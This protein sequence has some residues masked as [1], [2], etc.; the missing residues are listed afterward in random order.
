ML[1]RRLKTMSKAAKFG[2]V[3]VLLLGVAVSLSSN[4]PPILAIG[5]DPGVGLNSRGPFGS[6]LKG[7][8]GFDTWRHP[9]GMVLKVYVMEQGSTASM[10]FEFSGDEVWPER[11]QTIKPA[12]FLD[13]SPQDSPPIPSW[14]SI[15][16]SPEKVVLQPKG[17]VNVT[18]FL[19]VGK[20]ASRGEYALIFG[21]AMVYDDVPPSKDLHVYGPLV[22]ILRVGLEK[23]SHAF[24]LIYTSSMVSGGASV[25][26]FAEG[27]NLTALLVKLGRNSSVNLNFTVISE[28]PETINARVRLANVSARM[29]NV[30]F[31]NQSKGEVEVLPNMSSRANVTIPGVS[32]TILMGGPGYVRAGDSWIYPHLNVTISI[33]LGSNG[34]V[35]EGAYPTL[36]IFET[37][38]WVLD[39]NRLDFIKHEIETVEVPIFISVGER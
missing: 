13:D 11:N 8:A 32:Q 14:L 36:F 34:E 25:T 33:M 5:G 17:R 26:Q 37:Y 15:S 19:N 2:V 35:V 7:F 12:I 10:T 31:W 39:R 24:K 21:G 6:S 29:A 23:P 28:Y 27:V 18:A 22:F 16:F 3:L 20:D 9:S 30:Y 38:I 1:S 4:T